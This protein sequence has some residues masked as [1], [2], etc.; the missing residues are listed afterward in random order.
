[1]NNTNFTPN[2]L[3][4]Q[5]RPLSMWEY[6]GYSLLFNIPVVGFVFLIVFSFS[7]SNI[8]R[9]NYARSYFC[10]L[11]LFIILIV[12]LISAGAMGSLLDKFNPRRQYHSDTPEH[13]CIRFFGTKNADI[14]S[15]FFYFPEDTFFCTEKGAVCRK[16]L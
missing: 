6:F 8:N 12:I 3:P 5:Y 7:G 16:L 13:A 9:R 10:G 14:P 15:A 1:M 11:I 2:Q 4:E